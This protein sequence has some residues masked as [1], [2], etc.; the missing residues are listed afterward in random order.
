MSDDEKHRRLTPTG[1][2][3]PLRYPGGKGKLAKYVRSII[4]QNDL[5]DGLYVEPYA[6]G[7]AV[8]WELLLTGVVRRVAINDISRP[9]Y[10]FW[11]AVLNRTDEFCG[12]VMERPVTMEEWRR[13][14]AIFSQHED[15]A[16]LELAF[17]FFFLNRTNRSGIL[18]GGVI[19]GKDQTGQWKIDA[20]FNK[21]ALI[22][23][24]QAIARF[25][26]RVELT[27]MDAVD[28]I[29]RH[30]GSW[31]RNT[32]VYLDPP[33][34]EKG[35]YLYHDAYE[36]DDHG[37]IASAVLA[38][39]HVDW[40]VSYD[41]VRPIHDLYGEA[42]WLQYNLG[43]SARNRVRGREAMFFSEG[44]IVPDVP[45][46]LQELSRGED[47]SSPSYIPAPLRSFAA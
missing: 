20:R 13:C 38:M 7:A 23:R 26:S 40:I 46:P 42:T 14:K 28:L 9:I 31:T 5:S 3:S 1:R 21:T 37:D 15:A 12:L 18:N 24:I 2:F 8:A 17:A 27:C 35:R 6:G 33:Y 16:E 32:L 45:P 44:L 22:D 34:F 39:K 4:R 19:G 47:S 30:S 25:R 11:D 41:D 29:E 43:Y 36:P 10:C